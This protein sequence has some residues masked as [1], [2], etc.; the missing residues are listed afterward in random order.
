[1]PRA[2]CR[3]RGSKKLR[4]DLYATLGVPRDASKADIR[5]GYRR[6]AKRAHPD[7]GGSPEAFRQVQTAQLVLIDDARRAR[8]DETGQFEADPPVDIREA[9]ALEQLSFALDIALANVMR[10]NGDPREAD[11]TAETKKVIGELRRKQDQEIAAFEKAAAQWERLR[12]RF[13]ASNKADPNRMEALVSGKLSQITMMTAQA[14]S[15]HEAL[16]QAEAILADHTYRRDKQEPAPK[17]GPMGI[18]LA[19]LIGRS[20]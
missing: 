7:A 5:K 11:M 12:N 17:Q 13:T 10:F 18:S 2:K 8:Y 19:Q 20:F 16:G 14:K 6:A 15:R 3:S 9:M 4:S 1:M